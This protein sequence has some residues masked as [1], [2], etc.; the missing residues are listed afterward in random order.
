MSSHIRLKYLLKVLNG[1]FLWFSETCHFNRYSVQIPYSRVM[2]VK[3]Y[4]SQFL[5]MSIFEVYTES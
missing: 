3:T 4:C 2:S 5:V 1:V